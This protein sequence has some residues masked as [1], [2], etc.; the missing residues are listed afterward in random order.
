MLYPDIIH[1]YKD[2]Y[3]V[4]FRDSDTDGSLR[5]I[6]IKNGN[7]ISTDNVLYKF[8]NNNISDL[9][10]R[11]IHV[12]DKVYAVFYGDKE[13]T[14]IRGGAVITMT[15]SDK[16]TFEDTI[17]YST[18]L[19]P[20]DWNQF[21]NPQMLHIAGDIFAVTYRISTRAEIKTFEISTVGIINNHTSDSNW[22]YAYQ[23]A[24]SYTISNPAIIQVSSVNDTYAIVYPK[25]ISSDTNNGV[26]LT[27]KIP[28]NG[29][30]EKRVLDSVLLGPVNF[31]TP[32]IIHISG[33]VY[34]VMSRAVYYGYMSLH[35][36]TISNLGK[37]EKTFIDTLN[38][39]MP[40]TTPGYSIK[41]T[42][43]IN[44]IYLIVFNN[45][46]NPAVTLKTV[47]IANDGTI[48]DMV[49]CSFNITRPG[50]SSFC[51]PN[52]IRIKDNIFAV[53]YH[54]TNY[55]SASDFLSTVQVSLAGNITLLDTYSTNAFFSSVYGYDEYTDIIPIEGSN[56]LY[57]LLYGYDYFIPGQHRGSGVIITVEINDTGDINQN[58]L[59]TTTF[60][61]YGCSRPDIIHIKNS[62]Y[63][64]TYSQTVRTSSYWIKGYL[65]TFN[66]SSNGTSITKVDDV[67]FTTSSSS[68][69]VAHSQFISHL[70][71]D[72]YALVYT[73]PSGSSARGYIGTFCIS[74]GGSIYRTA[75]N[76]IFDASLAVNSGV[77]VLPS[78][79]NITNN[80]IAVCYQGDYDDGYI[81]TARITISDTSATLKDIFSKAG[82]YAIKGN[83]TVF[84]ATLTTTSGDK[85][86]TLPVHNGWNYLVLTYD[87]TSMKFFNNLTNVSLLC[88]VNIK[89]SSTN[90][91]FGSF[92][93]MYDE[94]A[95]YKTHLRDD[96]IYDHFTQY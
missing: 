19:P 64:L 95:L 32:D 47:K 61:T 26:L 36:M 58:P 62:I 85:T 28:D 75:D 21:T 86:L 33:T 1:V 72:V 31:Y 54:S 50:Y 48:E 37:V 73:V 55:A 9:P 56:H 6:Q 34:A 10:L 2:Y 40:E 45:Y 80:I 29:S 87:H 71:A 67:S 8:D 74:T 59:T 12:F 81:E 96:E 66:F 7:I 51:S 17:D 16:G 44:D 25:T 88:S 24:S 53:S 82:S 27:V 18:L 89:T 93:G 49:L 57:A 5:S 94:F 4:V 70:Y 15:L 35:T 65:Q 46:A 13:G 23:P 84:T 39:P 38:I 69:D 3:S 68:Y 42:H 60:E 83:R 78:L 92:R 41:I 91:I 43:A 22:K 11:I 76:V 20:A 14:I 52:V 90:L 79:I 77:C 63:A 30:I